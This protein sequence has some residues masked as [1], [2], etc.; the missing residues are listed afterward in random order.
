MVISDYFLLFFLLR[1]SSFSRTLR[2]IEESTFIARKKKN[3]ITLVNLIFTI[4]I[5]A[6]LLSCL[7]IK[8]AKIED[9][10]GGYSW[11]LKRNIDKEEW[12]IQYIES[13]YFNTVTMVTVGYGDIYPV[14]PAE[15]VVSIVIMIVSCGVFAYSVNTIGVVFTNLAGEEQ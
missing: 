4:V 9:D 2:K 5:I 3:M 12:Y 13:Y 8:I 11:L 6:H 15:Q 1:L 10:L 7:R 14:T